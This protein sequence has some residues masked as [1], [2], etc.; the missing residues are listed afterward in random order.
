MTSST[1][2]QETNELDDFYS[3][4]SD[5]ASTSTNEQSSSTSTST[6]ST[7]KRKHEDIDN[8]TTDTTT[9]TSNTDNG[10]GNGNGT[11]TTT[12]TTSTPTTSTSTSTISNARMIPPSL[13]RKK[14]AAASSAVIKKPM[15][16]SS[17]ILSSPAVISSKAVTYSANTITK[18]QE[19][20]EVRMPSYNSHITREKPLVT[21][22]QPK[23]LKYTMGAA[24]QTWEDPSLSEW[25]PNDYRIFVGDLGNDV[26]DDMLRQSFCKYPS[27][28]KAKVLR[29]KRTLKSKGFGFVSFSDS[30]DYVKAMREMNGKYVG[31]RPIK[32]RKS[33]WKDRAESVTPLSSG[34]A[35][36]K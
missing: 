26:T 27:F 32:L 30:T 29:D 31:N 9:S 33:S 12:T 2:T 14:A 4:L 13:M 11:G 19:S 36:K 20:N 6:T 8:N 3:S 1:D 28:L 24:G 18:L 10:N 23:K 34:S 21:M 16:S 22:E 15:V 7:L 5:I 35:A 17:A 25:D